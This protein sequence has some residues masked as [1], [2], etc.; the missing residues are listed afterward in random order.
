MWNLLKKADIEQAKQ[1][2]N[3]RRAETL[4]RHAEESQNL[5]ADRAEAETLNRLADLFAQ[6]YTK[7]AK[8]SHAPI[9]TPV[10]TQKIA[11]KTSSDAR[12]HPHH[13]DHHQHR[14][15][16]QTVFATFMR[17]ASRV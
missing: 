16:H 9:P 17:A 1:K 15:Q 2:L 4:K 14:H 6:K 13:R 7:P 8:M 11:D 10:S 5:D 12:H 3:L